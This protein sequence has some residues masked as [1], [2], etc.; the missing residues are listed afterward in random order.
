MRVPRHG[1]GDPPADSES[2][3]VKVFDKILFSCYSEK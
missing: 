2:A 3:E 1:S